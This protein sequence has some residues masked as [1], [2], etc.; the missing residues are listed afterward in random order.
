MVKAFHTAELESLL[1]AMDRGHS[2]NGRSKSDMLK[3][4]LDY[5]DRG[6]SSSVELK[7]KDLYGKRAPSSSFSTSSHHG[8][9]SS[10]SRSHSSSSS[11]LTAATKHSSVKSSLSGL[12]AFAF[13]LFVF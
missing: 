4:V 12:Y 3:R 11:S 7:I 8:S 2:R 9:S 5:I 6:V 13:H 1:N 10:H